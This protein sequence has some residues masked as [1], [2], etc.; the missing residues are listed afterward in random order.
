MAEL[1]GTCLCGK[2]R[3]TLTAVPTQATACSCSACR[4]FGALW[5]YGDLGD[6]V[7]ITGETHGFVRDDVEAHLAFHTCTTCGVL[8]SWQ[9]LSLDGSPRCAVNL[10]LA[11]AEAVADIPVRRFDGGGTWKALPDEGRTVGDVWF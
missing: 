8:V 3:W 6:T 11:D 2:V 4:R 9:P 10:R 5:A 7:Q 1:T